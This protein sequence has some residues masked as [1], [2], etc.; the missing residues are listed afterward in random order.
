MAL[1]AAGTALFAQ[2]APLALEISTRTEAPL[3]RAEAE[4]LKR[5]LLRLT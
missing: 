2:L 3:T 5:L 1:T 4:V